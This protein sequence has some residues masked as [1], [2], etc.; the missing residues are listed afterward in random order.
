MPRS[1][2]DPEDSCRFRAPAAED[3]QGHGADSRG[4][5][6]PRRQR[7]RVPEVGPQRRQTA[8]VQDQAGVRKEEPEV[9]TDHRTLAQEARALPQEA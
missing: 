6:G 2:G 3:S 5:G 4:A 7:C 8:S 1:L 9:G